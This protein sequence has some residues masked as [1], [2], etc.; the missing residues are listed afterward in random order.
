MKFDI[1]S[2]GNKLST[3]WK[4]Y[5][6]S[7]LAFGSKNAPML[8]TGGSILLG[9]TAVYIFWKQGKKAEEEIRQEE[10]ILNERNHS[11]TEQ[12]ELPKKQKAIIYL[13]YCWLALALGV[14]S[15]GLAIGAQKLTLDR[16]AE[17]YVMTQFLTDKNEK[18]DKLI[19]KFKKDVGEKKAAVIKQ[20]TLSEDFTDE[21]VCAAWYNSK[22]NS[23]DSVVLDHVMHGIR[24]MNLDELSSGIYKANDLLRERLEKLKDKYMKRLQGSPFYVNGDIQFINSI[25][26]E[27]EAYY[28]DLHS[29]ID[30]GEF[31]KC[32]HII[33]D[34]SFGTRIGEINEIRFYGGKNAIN[35]NQ[36]TSYRNYIIPEGIDAGKT[37]TLCDLDYTEI[38]AP[39]QE[40]IERN[41]L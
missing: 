21:E 38:L 10:K 32:I 20:E 5:G 6:A 26:A 36:I 12:L 22:A 9:W 2:F 39:T 30:L 16:L 24:R 14:A 28:T 25:K 40:L 11:N 8:M 7:L 41:P 34:D 35:Q 15:S 4:N 31:L 3:T 37:I 17:M 27:E 19:E 18:K 29:S 33:P 1:S 13:Q 23:G